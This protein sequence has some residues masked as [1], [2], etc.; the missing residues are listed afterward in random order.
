[1]RTMTLEQ[2][3]MKEDDGVLLDIYTELESRVIPAT[4]YAHAFCRKVNRMIDAGE[5]CTLP[6]KYRKIYLP[7]LSK[8]IFKEMSR[9]YAQVLYNEKTLTPTFESVHD[10]D[11]DD[12]PH[13]C[14]WCGLDDF[15]PD[16]LHGTD[17][18]M[19]CDRCI[20]AI[21]SRGEEVTVFD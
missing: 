3:L 10:G 16:Q 13:T 21:R 9:R 2:L 18:G 19:L 12:E 6:D 1:M 15:E 5:L 8:M 17:L 7:S 4:G 14:A 11:A 20:A